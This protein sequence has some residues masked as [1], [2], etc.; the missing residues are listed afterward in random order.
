M[1]SCSGFAMSACGEAPAAPEPGSG[2]LPSPRR[3]ANLRTY[4]NIYF[5]KQRAAGRRGAKR[6]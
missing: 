3:L 1:S 6:R 2:D 5:I 4:S